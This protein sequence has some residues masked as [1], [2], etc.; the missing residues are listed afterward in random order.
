ML[1]KEYPEA[2]PISAKTGRGVEVLVE[3]VRSAM[4]GGMKTIDFAVDLADG[5]AISFLENRGEVLER[6]W[7]DSKAFFKV[8]I[9]GRQLDQLWAMGTTARVV[10]PAGTQQR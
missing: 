9:G 4:R 5:K 1:Q 3:R 8:R 2:L 7:E 6:R 10:E